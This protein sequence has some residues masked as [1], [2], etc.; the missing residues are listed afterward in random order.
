[1]NAAFILIFCEFTVI[2]LVELFE[3]FN[4]TFNGAVIILMAVDP[5]VYARGRSFGGDRSNR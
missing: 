3:Y 1:M 4:L 5:Q 2:T